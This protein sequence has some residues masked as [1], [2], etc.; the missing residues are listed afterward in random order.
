LM[1]LLSNYC[2]KNDIKTSITVGIVGFPNVG[3]SSVINSL[4]RT[5]A[6]ETGSMPGI[7]KQM[8]TVKLDKLIKLFDSPGIVMS[9]ETSPA[10]LI[11]RNCIRVS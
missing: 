3:K 4:K 1:N 10:S 2:R 11:L 8:Q 5:Q 9:K 6:C 7:T